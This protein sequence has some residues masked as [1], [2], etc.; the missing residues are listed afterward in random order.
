MAKRIVIFSTKGGVGKTVIAANLAVSLAKNEF[1]RVCLIDLDTHAVG[2]M[3]RMLNLKPQ[4]AA[5]DLINTLTKLPQ[6][7]L[8]KEEFVVRNSS[9][10]MDFLA[11]VLRPQQSP[12]LEADKIGAV[13]NLLDK[14]YDFIIIDAGKSFNEVFVS[15]L[16]QANLILLV[17]TPDILSVYQTKWILD[18]LQALRFPLAMIKILLNR[19]ESASSISWQEVKVSLPVDII[20]RIPSDGKAVGDSVNRSVPV[21]L[22]SPRSKMSQAVSSLA[23]ELTKNKKLFIEHHELGELSLKGSVLEKTGEFWRAQGL[24]EALM[25]PE[26][27]DESDEIILLKRRIHNRLIEELNLKRMDVK[28]FSDAKKTKDLRDKAA[29]MVANFLAEEAKSFISSPDVRKKLV[30]EILDE[31]LGLGPLEDLLAD[32][33]ITDIMVN[34]KDEVYI[35]RRGKIELTSKK[36]ISNEQVKTIIERIIAPIGRRIDESVPM[37]DARLADGSRVNAIIP[38]LSLTGPS[39]TIR[40]FRKERFTIEELIRL[41]S[42]SQAMA[43]FIKASVLCR[44]NIIV[45]G[46]TG[47]GKTSV[48][49]VLSAF[50][51]D[52][53][54]IITIEDAAELKLHQEHWVRLESRPPNIEGKGALTIRDLF[55]NTLRMRPDRILIGECRGVETLDMLQAMNTGHDG[56]MTTVHANSTHDV[57]TRLDSMI[58]MS[59]VELPIRAIREMIASAI[60]IIVHTARL[61]DG[62][63]KVIQITEIAGMKDELHIDLQDIFAFKQT[64]ID[65]QGN[66]LGYFSATGFLPS[67]LEEIKV[68]GIAL[69]D[70]LF[71][72]QK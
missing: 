72:P 43:D 57:L 63:R 19:A 17:V 32:P 27:L 49:N 25:E 4:K 31:A 60:D 20:A 8:K 7:E 22:D 29:M 5:V 64:G 26:A 23:K 15:T 39:L 54:R 50:I 14:H 59:G 40:K 66:V 38:P 48:L 37:V 30:K 51:P 53:E 9:L 33:E 55:R 44:K 28:T 21:V 34:N 42:L 36:F 65:K 58:L 52:S 24:T 45:S 61:S 1:A 6:Q 41:N 12:H 3:A 71:Q 10:G 35:E 56:S 47:S 62:S 13:C 11:G 16:N 18:T 67:F 46:G 70:N 2:D 68:K 69:P